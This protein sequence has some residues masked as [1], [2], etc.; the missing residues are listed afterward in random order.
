M[1]AVLVEVTIP[2]EADA[3]QTLEFGAQ[4]KQVSHPVR[5]IE[6]VEMPN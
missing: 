6:D 2:I 5:C 4:R 1:V 3:G